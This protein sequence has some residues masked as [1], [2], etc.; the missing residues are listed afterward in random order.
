[1]PKVEEP[2][3]GLVADREDPHLVS[4]TSQSSLYSEG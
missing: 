4:K 1:M 3:G 2:Q